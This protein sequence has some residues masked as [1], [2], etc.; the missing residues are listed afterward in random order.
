MAAPAVL[1][2]LSKASDKNKLAT[3]L[4]RSLGDLSGHK[5][6][7]NYVLLALYIGGEKFA[8][9]TLFRPDSNKKEDVYQSHLGLYIKSGYSAFKHQDGIDELGCPVPGEWVI[10]RGGGQRVQINGIDCHYIHEDNILGT[11]PDPST[12][13]HRL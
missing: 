8:G 7:K 2:R 9:S 4:M 6:T 10:H 1:D 5:V 3:E 11:V 13:T 12:I